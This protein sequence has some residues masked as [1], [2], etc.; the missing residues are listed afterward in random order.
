M[1]G[2]KGLFLEKPDIV[3]KYCRRLINEKNPQLAEM[4][5]IQFARMYQPIH[6]KNISDEHDENEEEK[7]DIDE[8]IN[9]SSDIM[10]LWKDE[11]D[12]IANYYITVIQAT[13]LILYLQ[14]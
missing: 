8:N 10:P 4:S 14:Q 11:E 6:R 1:G 5:L 3:D 12:R 7:K 2:R 13:I 9:T